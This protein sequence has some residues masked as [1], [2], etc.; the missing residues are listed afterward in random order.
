MILLN[1]TKEDIKNLPKPPPHK[2]SA[3]LVSVHGFP[4]PA[5]A[6]GHRKPVLLQRAWDFGLGVQGA[7]KE[8]LSRGG[9]QG[10]RVRGV[11]G[12]RD[13]DKLKVQQHTRTAMGC[14]ISPLLQNRRVSAEGFIWQNP[15]VT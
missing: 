6:L 13:T 5:V 8:R 11:V 9:F 2:R 3:D 1:P 12:G 14:E 4:H 15:R 10:C 7:A